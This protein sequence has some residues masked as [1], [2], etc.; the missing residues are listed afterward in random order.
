MK[1]DWKYF[2]QTYG[3]KKLKAAVNADKHRWP[4]SSE[5]ARYEKFFREII[6][7]VLKCSHQTGLKPWVILTSLEEQRDYWYPN[8][9][10]WSIFVKGFGAKPNSR[11]HPSTLRGELRLIKKHYKKRTIIHWRGKEGYRA[12]YRRIQKKYGKPSP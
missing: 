12:D 6:S 8:F 2:A 1:V 5:K 4:N 3:Y 10:R 7:M 9:Y 11:L